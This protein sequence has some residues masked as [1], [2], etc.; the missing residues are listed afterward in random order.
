[1]F[2]AESI[3]TGGM[4]PVGKSVQFRGPLSEP[5][6]RHAEL[7]HLRRSSEFLLNIDGS[8]IGLAFRQLPIDSMIVLSII[9]H[10]ILIFDAGGGE[11]EEERQ[12]DGVEAEGHGFRL[13]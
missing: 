4:V 2:A 7:Q 11:D 13:R 5:A 9:F 10:S 8:G 6:G 12:D 1:M 3:P